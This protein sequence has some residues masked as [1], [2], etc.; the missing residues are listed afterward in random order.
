MGYLDDNDTL[1]EKAEQLSRLLS[2]S[3]SN[4]TPQLDEDVRQEPEEEDTDAEPSPSEHGWDFAPFYMYREVL[5]I[6][7]KYKGNLT[8][9]GL[10]RKR[11]IQQILDKYADGMP[12]EVD[13]DTEQPIF[14]IE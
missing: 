13:W 11:F 8:K 12:D 3:R 14:P 1:A 10:E 9:Q 6:S 4:S 7:E 2:G 5:K